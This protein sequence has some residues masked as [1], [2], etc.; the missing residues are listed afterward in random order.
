M[1]TQRSSY[2]LTTYIMKTKEIL[3]VVK[4]KLVRRK[5]EIIG[6]DIC[7]TCSSNSSEENFYLKSQ[8]R[9]SL[10]QVIF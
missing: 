9:L 2:V 7:I 1:A 6:T 4:S 3:L 8:A 10:V 5:L